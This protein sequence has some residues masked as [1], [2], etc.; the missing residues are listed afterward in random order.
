MYSALAG[1]EDRRKA[2]EIARTVS[3]EAID[4][5]STRTYLLAW[6]MGAPPQR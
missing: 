5:G 1:D 2:L 4:D 3:D 6:L